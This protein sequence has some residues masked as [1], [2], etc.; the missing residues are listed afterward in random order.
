MTCSAPDQKYPRRGS[1]MRAGLAL[2]TISAF[3]AGNAAAQPLI[4]RQLPTVKQIPSKGASVL[5]RPLLKV[6]DYWEYRNLTIKAQTNQTTRCVVKILDDGYLMET[7]GRATSLARYDKNL[8]W[9][10]SIGIDRTIRRPARSRVPRRLSFPSGRGKLGSTSTAPWT[11]T[12]AA[13]SRSKTFTP[14]KEPK[15]LKRRQE[16]SSRCASSGF[17]KTWRRERSLKASPGI[18]PASKTSSKCGAPGR[19]ER[20]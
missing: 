14:P 13:S 18:L 12:W 15:K 19:G 20:R 7:S 10:S 1:W 3:W 11:R 16:N 2:L 6:G 9:I 4:P 5:N 17:E 8:V